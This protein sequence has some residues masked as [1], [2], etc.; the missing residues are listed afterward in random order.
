MATKTNA[1]R[2][3]EHK[4]PTCAT[5]CRRHESYPVAPGPFAWTVVKCD[6]IPGRCCRECHEM[7]AQGKF[8]L[9]VG[10]PKTGTTCYYACCF[11]LDNAQDQIGERLQARRGNPAP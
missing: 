11:K 7:E 9:Q 8:G 6:Q 1:K 3:H 2:N 10:T 5:C 4:W